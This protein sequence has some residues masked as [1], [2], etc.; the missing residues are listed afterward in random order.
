MLA[1][2]MWAGLVIDL[3]RMVAAERGLATATDA[4]AAA[5]ANGLDE[6]WYRSTSEVRLDPG[7]ARAL[8]SDTMNAQPEATD[9]SDFSVTVASDAVTVRSAMPVRLSLL[10]LVVTHPLTVRASSTA[11]PRKGTP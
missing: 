9:V 2:L 1:L 5:G 7:R 4:A 8:A 11:G 3:S 10:G 6:G